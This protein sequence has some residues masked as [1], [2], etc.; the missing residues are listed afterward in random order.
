MKFRARPQ[1]QGTFLTKPLSAEK[2]ACE[3]AMRFEVVPLAITFI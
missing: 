3:N 2:G 1:V